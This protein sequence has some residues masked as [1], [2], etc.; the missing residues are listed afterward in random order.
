MQYAIVRSS[1]RVV[2]VQR[3]G[4]VLFVYS[5]HPIRGMP[6][7][8]YVSIVPVAKLNLMPREWTPSEIR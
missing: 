4:R 5:T 1:G 7:W 2:P 3:C 6:G 8:R